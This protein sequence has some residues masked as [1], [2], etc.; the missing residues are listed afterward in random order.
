MGLHRWVCGFVCNVK[1]VI[2]LVDIVMRGAWVTFK[3][4]PSHLET[5]GL[6]TSRPSEVGGF[7]ALRGRLFKFF[8]KL[9][10]SFGHFLRGID[11]SCVLIF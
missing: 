1:G 10:K 3:I 4:G 5:G 2:G 7:S 8:G 6:A 11:F 9:L